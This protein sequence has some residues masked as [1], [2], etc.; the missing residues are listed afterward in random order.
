MGGVCESRDAFRDR[1]A[2]RDGRAARECVSVCGIC[3]EVDVV[4]VGASFDGERGGDA[5]DASGQTCVHGGCRAL[6]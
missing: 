3:G 4:H 2:A 6:G 1:H 5:C